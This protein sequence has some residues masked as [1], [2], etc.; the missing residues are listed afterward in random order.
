M[1][2][3]RGVKLREGEVCK[4]HKREVCWPALPGS[5]DALQATEEE[6]LVV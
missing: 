4:G 3:E 5:G 1:R 6:P 2:E